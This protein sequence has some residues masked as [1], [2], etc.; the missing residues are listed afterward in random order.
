LLCHFPFVVTSLV[1]MSS[2]ALRSTKR[3][4]RDRPGHDNRCIK[5]DLS[6]R[7]AALS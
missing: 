4:G 5:S 6:L 1:P 3:D 7:T 2:L